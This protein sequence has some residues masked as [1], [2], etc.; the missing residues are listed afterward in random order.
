MGS[1]LFDN[2]MNQARQAEN[3]VPNESDNEK[4][5]ETPTEERAIVPA[6]D[7]RLKEANRLI[8]KRMVAAA[9]VG[10]LQFPLIDITVLTGIQ[11]ETVKSL[12]KI[13]DVPFSREMGR[14]AI[15]TL[16]G[17]IFSV[18]SGAFLGSLFKMMPFV[19][20]LAGAVSVSAIAGASTYAV[21]KVFLQHFAS[22]GTFLTF[23]PQAVR[24]HFQQEFE[25]G[26]IKYSLSKN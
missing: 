16:A 11:L 7:D 15:T 20:Q 26:K 8:S 18:S 3:D 13:Y 24:H 22:G 6:S 2:I 1:E 12:A 9:G 23:D 17:G 14:T 5:P 10:L 19:G 25:Q 4:E 21:G